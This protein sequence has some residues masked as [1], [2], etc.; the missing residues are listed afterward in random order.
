MKRFF[1]S[2]VWTVIFIAILIA[3]ILV[4]RIGAVKVEGGILTQGLVIALYNYMTQILVELIKLANLIISIT[5]ALNEFVSDVTD[6]KARE[7][8]HIC[9]TCDL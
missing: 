3:V 5:K 1:T 9:M 4:I 2:R 6:L 8:K 7:H